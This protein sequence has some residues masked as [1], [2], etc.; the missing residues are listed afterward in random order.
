[1]KLY[2]IY[3]SPFARRVGAALV[4]R[5]M[6]FE[7]DPINANEEPERAS[8]LNPVG[9]I[10]VLEL[11]DGT[12]LID[13]LCI[14]DAL[15]D[16]FGPQAVLVPSAGKLR[17]DMMQLA[18]ITTAIGE[19]AIG[20]QRE[21]G[22]PKEERDAVK[23]SRLREQILGGLRALENAADLLTPRNRK[24]LSIATICAVVAYEYVEM[25]QPEWTDAQAFPRLLSV[26]S[27]LRDESAFSATRYWSL[28]K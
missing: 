2:G 15:N 21:S 5:G 8:T 9:R 11:D 22:R 12:R 27:S 26:V 25:A 4:S 20:W 19:Q 24:M 3:Y 18:A 16:V 17:R 28:T 14:L 23:L 1:M 13:S 6:Q 10:P 7:H